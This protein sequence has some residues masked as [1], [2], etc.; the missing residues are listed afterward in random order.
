MHSQNWWVICFQVINTSKT[1]FCEWHIRPII[2]SVSSLR[3][4]WKVQ[5]LVYFNQ[6]FSERTN[7]AYNTRAEEDTFIFKAGHSTCKTYSFSKRTHTHTHT[8][9]HKR[10]HAHHTTD[11]RNRVIVIDRNQLHYFKIIEFIRLL[12]QN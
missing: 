3:I 6:Y 11:N 1:C 9:T 7:Q 10:T 5:C 2:R 4:R 12:F 8:H